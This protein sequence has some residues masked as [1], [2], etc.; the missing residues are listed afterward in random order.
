MTA[1]ERPCSTNLVQEVRCKDGVDSRNAR[2]EHLMLRQCSSFAAQQR[3]WRN[4]PRFQG[5]Q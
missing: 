4:A 1:R 5:A 2:E 3:R